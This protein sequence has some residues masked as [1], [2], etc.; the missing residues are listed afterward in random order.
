MSAFVAVARGGGFSAASR[1]LVVVLREFEPEP[2]PVSL[3]Y[4]RDRLLPSKTRAFLDF[5]T[6]RLA[7]DMASVAGTFTRPSRCVIVER[8]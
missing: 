5:A 2:T 6:P 7:E 8:A 3:V 4:P 1:A